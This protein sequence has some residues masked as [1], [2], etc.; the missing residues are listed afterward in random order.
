MRAT[1]PRGTPRRGAARWLVLALVAV[2][3][4]CSGP[5]FEE[6]QQLGG[7]EIAPEILERGRSVW[8]NRC[9]RCHGADGRGLTTAMRADRPPPNLTTGQF[10]F[11]SVPDGGLPTDDDLRKVIRRGVGDDW[12]PPMD[13]LSEA[14]VDAVVHY[15]KTFS[16][17]WRDDE[18][19]EPVKLPPDP[20][21]DKPADAIERGRTVFHGVAKCWTCHPASML[22]AE[23]KILVGG[24][25]A[26]RPDLTQPVRLET[27]RGS[28]RAPDLASD[29]LA[30]GDALEDLATVISVG[31]G[32]GAMPS[33]RE[34]VGPSDLWAVARYVR[35]L[36]AARRP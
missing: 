11:S 18:A 31:V 2:P 15:V 29:V 21:T 33:W 23:L 26:D 30:G 36:R 9:G 8:L 3:T 13:G 12:M 28:V 17:R 22:T 35:S 32:G 1:S 6:P 25:P 5:R 10:R 20:W 4:G 14:D 19:G 27:P 24:L 7:V 34:S 16:S